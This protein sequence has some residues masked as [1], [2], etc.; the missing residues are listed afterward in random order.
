MTVFGVSAP[1]I[2]ACL[3]AGL[4]P[5]E[6]YDLS[7]MRAL[8]STGAP[9]SA[10][11]FRWVGE[12]AGEDIQICSISGGTDVCT[13]SLGSAPPVP[14]WLGELSCACLGADVGAVD[15][16]GQVLRDEMGELVIGKPMP[17]MPVSFW[18]DPDGVRLRSRDLTMS[19]TRW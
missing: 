7:S 5:R 14:V 9:L 10:E 11:G 13:A 16:Q 3:K 8:G 4:R 1:F 18:N 2:Q 19:W 6:S 12:A 15:E 17:S